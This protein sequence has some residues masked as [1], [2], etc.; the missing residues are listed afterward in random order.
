VLR[1][2]I[3]APASRADRLSPADL[4]HPTPRGRPFTAEGWLFELKHDGFRAFARKSGAD[5][6]LLSRWG[7]SMANAFPE[8]VD[9]VA[10]LPGDVVLDA[11]LVVTDEHGRSDFE[12]LRRRALLQRAWL[13]ERAAAQRPATLIVFD[14]LGAD[15]EDLRPLSLAQRKQWLQRN[16]TP[17]PRLRVD[18][19][20]TFGEAS[21]AVVSEHDFEGIVAKRFDAPYRAGRKP[22]WRKVKNAAYSRREALVWRA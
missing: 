14:V 13:I 2:P 9:A 17:T 3:H 21:F 5:V 8:V 15:G 16:V 1:S 19:V 22:T 20:P 4:C 12:E 10:R 7:R 18:C 11:E 6:Y